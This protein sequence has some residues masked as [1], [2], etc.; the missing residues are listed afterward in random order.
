MNTL[1]FTGEGNVLSFTK[2]GDDL[3]IKDNNGITISTLTDI[4]KDL[5]TQ[6]STEEIQDIVGTMVSSNTE[7]NISVN[8][9]D[10]SGKL[11]FVATDTNTEYSV[12]NGELS[13][14][15]FTSADHTK[16]NGISTGAGTFF[17]DVKFANFQGSS[18]AHEFFLPFTNTSEV[19]ASSGLNAPTGE[20]EKCQFIAIR[21]G[22]IVEIKFRSE[23]TQSNILGY[24]VQMEL[25]EAEDGQEIVAR[26]NTKIGSS[27]V[28]YSAI[29]DDTTKTF[30]FSDWDLTEG[31][32]YGIWAKF[33]TEP[34]DTTISILFKYTL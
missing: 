27:K 31:R 34:R 30:T 4:F 15:N 14:I 1:S 28:T 13:E 3:I 32:A 17:Y 18:S 24:E 19:G 25:C 20:S 23:I 33:I 7:T 2:S 12:G 29:D 22:E 16:L 8:Y 26:D 11:N 21:D 10:T 9:N 6:L 5:N